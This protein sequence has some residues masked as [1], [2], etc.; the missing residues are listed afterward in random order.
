MPGHAPVQHE[1]ERLLRDAPCSISLN[2]IMRETN[3]EIARINSEG[4]RCFCKTRGPCGSCP[5]QICVGRDTNHCSQYICGKQQFDALRSE[6]GRSLLPQERN[7]TSGSVGHVS[8]NRP[9]AARLE[10]KAP[11]VPE[12]ASTNKCL[13]PELEVSRK[14]NSIT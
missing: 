9:G 2:N 1:P 10:Q 6:G 12:S 5:C 14:R 13:S 3:K 11:P 7:L 4:G 8:G